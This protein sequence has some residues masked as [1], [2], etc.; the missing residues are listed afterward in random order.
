MRTNEDQAVKCDPLL[1]NLHSA[2]STVPSTIQ[3]STDYQQQPLL[4]Q[5]AVIDQLPLANRQ[6]AVA[7]KH[8]PLTV[9][10]QPVTVESVGEANDSTQSCCGP[11]SKSAKHPTQCTAPCCSCPKL[12][13]QVQHPTLQQASLLLN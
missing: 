6:Q 9:K 13:C 11:Q 3:S 4:H 1:T 12:C 2:I 8:L 5:S 7:I 10:Q